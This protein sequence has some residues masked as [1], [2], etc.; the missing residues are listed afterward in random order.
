MI[1]KQRYTYRWKDAN[2]VDYWTMS[3]EYFYTKRGC[4]KRIVK[5][6]PTNPTLHCEMTYQVLYDRYADESN[7]SE[8]YIPLYELRS[9]P[10]V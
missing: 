3:G 7:P 10:R 9:I 8:A 6:L 4:L 2:L 1:F 5:V